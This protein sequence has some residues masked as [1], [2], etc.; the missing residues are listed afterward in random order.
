MLARVL[1]AIIAVA[2]VGCAKPATQPAVDAAAVRDSITALMNQ[3]VTALRNNDPAGVTALWADDAVYM[4]A[5]TPTVVG[6]AA[7]DSVVH[8]IFATA[9]LTEVT[10][11]TDEILVDHDIAVQR[12]TFLEILQPQRGD[13]VTLR[14][15]YLFVWHRQADGSW[16]IARGMG[17]PSP[18][19]SAAP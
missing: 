19:P 8:G 13:P 16:K 2:S 1:M 3:Y 18:E 6:R 4:N 17:T 15:R 14:G 5:G 9:R 10:E 12:G 11:D 7:F